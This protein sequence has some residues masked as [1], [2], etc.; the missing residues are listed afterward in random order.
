MKTLEKVDIKGIKIAT[1]PLGEVEIQKKDIIHF[2][3]GIFAFEHLKKYTLIPTK[4]KLSFKWL[5]SLEDKNIAFLVTDPTGFLPNYSP[6][7][8]E[9]RLS[10]IEA[11]TH[12][13]VNLYCIVTVPF[14]KPEAMTINLQGPIL[15]NLKKMLAAQLISEDESH[16]IREPL[17][18]LLENNKM[19]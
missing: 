5:Q 3:E 10:I 7:I 8:Y 12:T 11:K 1:K 18:K 4:K 9:E 16:S 15:I 17:I 13:D 2:P 6:A 14:N 19:F